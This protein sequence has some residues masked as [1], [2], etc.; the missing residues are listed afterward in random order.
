MHELDLQR[1]IE[2][3]EY[4]LTQILEI[5]TFTEGF[6][7]DAFLRNSMAKN[8]SLMKLI[9]FGEYSA[10]IDERLKVRFS[11]IQWQ[12]IKA[13]RNYYA[14]VYHG[15]NWRIVWEVIAIELPGLRKNIENI[16]EVLESEKQNAK[17]NQ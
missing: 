1:E 14:H 17:T 9:I 6:D 4:L 13:A 2:M 12:L 7:E 5:E 3:F 11:E 10:R 16:I 8:A 15:I